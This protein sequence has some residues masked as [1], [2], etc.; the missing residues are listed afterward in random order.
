[1]KRWTVAYLS[2]AC[3]TLP[4]ACQSPDLSS[5]TVTDSAGVQ[6]TINPDNSKT[7]GLVSDEPI[8][9]IGGREAA[10]PTQFSNIRDIL[11]DTQGNLWV[12]D[13]ASNEVRAFRPNGDQWKTIGRTGEGPGEFLRIRLLGQFAPDSLALWD[14]ASS[15]LTV[16]GPSADVVRTVDTW[17]G[18]DRQPQAFGIYGD[19]TVLIVEGR[20]LAADGLRPG[21]AWQDTLRLMRLNATAGTRDQ[22]ALVPSVSWVWTGQTQLPLP[23]SASASYV[24]HENEL[25]AASGVEFRVQV[26]SNGR[27]QRSYG[28]KRRPRPVTSENRE[29]WIR[30]LGDDSVRQR[31]QL[32]LLDHPLAGRSLPAYA[33]LLRSNAGEI[34][35]R[36]YSVDPFAA[37]WWDVYTPSGQ[38]LGQIE[39][40]EMFIVRAIDG[41][42]LIGVWYD[43]LGVEHVRVHAITR[44][45]PTT[46]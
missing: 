40:P 45:L 34:W 36:V 6:I 39:T 3:A 24:V 28:V 26:F 25:H 29:A 18:E 23:F 11:V 20:L 12:A 21:S 32:P 17:S 42:R 22:L 38:W 8:L 46:Q 15:R 5:A 13:G 41:E 43:D 4:G 1:V 7:Y 31:E 37:A 33:Q 9:T 2:I 35:A 44:I 14:D 19:G 10:G 27:L 30:S 16:Y